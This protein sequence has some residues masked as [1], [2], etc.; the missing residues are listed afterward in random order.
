LESCSAWIFTA[1]PLTFAARKILSV[2]AGLKAIRSQNTSTASA[3]PSRA[4]AGIISS[5]T[6]ST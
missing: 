1:N 5:H 3:S 4:A 6:R 2:C